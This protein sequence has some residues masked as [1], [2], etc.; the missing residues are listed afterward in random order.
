MRFEQL[1]LFER[2][3]ELHHVTHGLLCGNSKLAAEFG[4]NLAVVYW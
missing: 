3:E 4:R 2:A 1:I